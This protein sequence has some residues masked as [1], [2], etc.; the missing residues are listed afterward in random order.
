[1]ADT[2]PLL[3]DE[4]TNCSDFPMSRFIKITVTGDLSHL[5]RCADPQKL[6]AEIHSEY[7]EL[8]N[9]TQS[10][11]GLELAKSIS[12]LTNRINVTNTIVQ[13]LAIRGRID[14]LVQEL[15]NMGYRLKYNDL[16]K[17]LQRTLS[18]SKSDHVKLATAKEQYA[19]LG[20]GDKTTNFQWT[21]ILS[22]L[23]KYRQVVS[24]NPALITVSEYVAMDIDFRA[25]I[26]AMQ[27]TNV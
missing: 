17:D 9:D 10:S 11:R 27:K 21:Q 25:Y 16:D 7:T 4:F 3:T 6:W 5:G 23:A 1:M 13:H 26:R 14:E 20:E 19:K 8:T 18:L 12:V 22:A 15:V 24:I 2:Q